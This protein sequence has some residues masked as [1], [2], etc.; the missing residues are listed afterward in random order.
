MS[1][2]CQ[3]LLCLSILAASICAGSEPLH[4]RIKIDVD[5][6]A[7]PWTSLDFNDDADNFQFAV[8][9]DRTGRARFGV[10]EDAIAK[11]NLLQPEFVMSVGDLIQ[12]GIEDVHEIDL[13]WDELVGF[14][15]EL[16]MPFFHVPGNHD[17]T[18]QVMAR[19]WKKRFGRSYYHFVYKDVLFLCLNT[20][21]PPRTNMS[22][23]Q[24]EYVRSALAENSDVRWTLVFL[25]KPMWTY[26]DS[27]GFENI[28]S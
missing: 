27:K 24:V 17:I 4:P 28:E 11:L 25:H 15:Q 1:F 26:E 7:N 3:A 5:P 23:A 20:Q 2:R 10:F 18:N 12:G 22:D 13:Q 21:D 8:V 6:G 19:V 16:D 14:A 9:A